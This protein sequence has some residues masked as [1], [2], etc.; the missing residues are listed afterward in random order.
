MTEW[1]YLITIRYSN[2]S[3]TA[4]GVYDNEDGLTRAQMI[5]HIYEATCQGR[6][7]PREYTSVT[8][9]YLEPNRAGVN[10]GP[11]DAGIQDAVPEGWRV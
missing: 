2:S 1:A 10:V 4:T 7:W 6:R 9:L 8:T 5:D 11:S 3:H